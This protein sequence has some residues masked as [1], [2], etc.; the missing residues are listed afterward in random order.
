VNAT[1]G[2]LTNKA[3]GGHLDVVK[4]LQINHTEF[5]LHCLRDYMTLLFTEMSDSLKRMGGESSH[6][7]KVDIK[8]AVDLLKETIVKTNVTYSVVSAQQTE[9]LIPI[10]SHNNS[11]NSNNNTNNWKFQY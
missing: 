5:Q 4:W 6:N 3:D 9:N 2:P 10:N 7:D 1:E 11:N 8:G